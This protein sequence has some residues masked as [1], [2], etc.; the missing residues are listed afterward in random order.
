MS[1]TY[2]VVFAWLS[3]LA[4]CG[5]SMGTTSPVELYRSPAF[6]SSGNVLAVIEIPAGT[7]RKTEYDPSQGKFV[8][9]QRNGEDRIIDFL[10][11]PGNYGFIPST[12]LDE[13]AGGDGDALDVLVICEAVP[14]GTLMEVIPIGALLLIDEGEKDTKIIAIPANPELRVIDATGFADFSVK[15]FA[16]RNIIEEWMLAYDGLGTTTSNGWR[17]DRFAMDEIKK[18][19]VK[20]NT[21]R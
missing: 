4:F 21:P 5:C 2:L 11:Y 20:N 18:C 16:A 10:P 15:Y 9:D 3:L 14:M 12:N 8:T 19:V 17:D 1:N 6:S 7:N 13:D